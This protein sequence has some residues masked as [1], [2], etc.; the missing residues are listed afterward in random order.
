[1]KCNVHFAITESI[2]TEY[3]FC[4][5]QDEIQGRVQLLTR[6]SIATFYYTLYYILNKEYNSKLQMAI[7]HLM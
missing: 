1:M 2:G 7:L 6:I 4:S 5:I 3:P